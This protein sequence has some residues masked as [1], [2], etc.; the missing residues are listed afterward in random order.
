MRCEVVLYTTEDEGTFEAVFV[1]G[2]RVDAEVTH[3]DPG[4][5]GWELREWRKERE[6]D[7]QAASVAAAAVIRQW[8]ADAESSRYISRDPSSEVANL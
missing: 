8:A 3:L 5:G 2:V 1:D 4:R 7:A 6:A